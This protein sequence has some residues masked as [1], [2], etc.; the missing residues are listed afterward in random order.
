MRWPWERETRQQAYGDAVVDLI[1]SRAGGA[2]TTSD[3]LAIAAVETA[4]GLWGR[5]F[6][7][8]AVLPNV[9]R[10]DAITPAVRELI[11]RELIRKGEACL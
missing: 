2:A 7:A 11:G 10:L 1:L 5:A 3:P 4:A 6:M 9:G 8:A